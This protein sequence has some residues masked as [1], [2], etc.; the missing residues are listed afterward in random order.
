MLMRV[1][2]VLIVI[3]QCHYDVMA[4]SLL[5]IKQYSGVSFA[6]AIQEYSGI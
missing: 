3:V 2:F 1:Y 4:I 6:D 5:K